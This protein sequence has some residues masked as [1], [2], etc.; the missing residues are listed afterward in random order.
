MQHGTGLDPG[1]IKAP[2]G[3]FVPGVARVEIAFVNAYLVGAPGGPWALV[4]TGLPL[5]SAA[6]I[7]WAV[8]ERYGDGA[9]PEAIVLTHG[10]FDPAGAALDLA[11]GWTCPSMRTRWR[12]LT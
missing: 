10:H 2:A 8:A 6:V 9:R 12:C 11:R 1:T 4:D 5:L 7:R 3:E